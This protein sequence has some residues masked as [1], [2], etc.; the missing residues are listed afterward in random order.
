MKK[1]LILLMAL[2]LG[3]CFFTAGTVESL[4]PVCDALG[5]PIHY[6]GKDKNSAWHA[7]P[8]LGGRLD[9]Q[10]GVGENLSC[11]GY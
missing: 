9:Q 11:P 7:G 3:G 10:Y 8:K 4:K 6:N 2:P 1:F 5:P